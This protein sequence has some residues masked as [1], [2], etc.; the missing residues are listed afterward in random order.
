MSF[1]L[2]LWP[3]RITSQQHTLAAQTTKLFKEE[4]AIVFVA[5]DL[6]C[7]GSN[8]VTAI[9]ISILYYFSGK[10]LNWAFRRAANTRVPQT[11]EQLI[12]RIEKG[13]IPI[14]EL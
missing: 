6:F 8:I 7:L 1:F 12:A 13:E 9:Y 4:L 11:R 5:F 2:S 14:I 10:E 3:T